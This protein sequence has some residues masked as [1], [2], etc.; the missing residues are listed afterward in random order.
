MSLL[1]LENT[2]PDSCTRKFETERISE[3]LLIFNSSLRCFFHYV[4]LNVCC[5]FRP[6]MISAENL[7]IQFEK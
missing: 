3:M 5:E 7:F 6:M 1:R 2:F 4:I